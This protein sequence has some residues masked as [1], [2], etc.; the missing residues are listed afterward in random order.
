MQKERSAL[1][2]SSA[3]RLGRKI[4]LNDWREQSCSSVLIECIGNSLSVYGYPLEA[5]GNQE[6]TMRKTERSM[7]TFR[8]AV[9]GA[10]LP[11]G[12]SRMTNNGTAHPALT[13]VFADEN[14]LTRDC[15]AISLSTLDTKITVHPVPS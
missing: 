14:S 3:E 15:F 10:G 2:D 12:G 1:N 11:N 9:Q 13:L 4:N 8:A 6:E 5:E 7:P